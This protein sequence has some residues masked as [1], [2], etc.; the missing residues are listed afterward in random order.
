ME[1]LARHQYFV[2]AKCMTDSRTLLVVAL[3]RCALLSRCLEDDHGLSEGKGEEGQ[4]E[5]LF[6][7]PLSASEVGAYLKTGRVAPSEYDAFKASPAYNEWVAQEH[8]EAFFEKHRDEINANI[9][10]LQKGIDLVA[11]CGDITRTKDQKKQ[12]DVLLKD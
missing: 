12:L 9:D 2:S 4:D 1:L 11:V 8:T 7:P 3:L 6:L 10:E 5:P